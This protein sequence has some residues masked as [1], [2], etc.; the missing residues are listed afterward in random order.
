[1]PSD[2][3]VAA[4]AARAAADVLLR[5]VLPAATAISVPTGIVTTLAG[6]VVLVWLARRLRAEEG[7]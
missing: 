2:V 5:L 1:M 3:E 6:A 4:A 7:P